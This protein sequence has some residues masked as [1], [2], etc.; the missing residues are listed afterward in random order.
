ME[1]PMIADGG[2]ADATDGVQEQVVDDVAQ[3]G[4]E[5][6][7]ERSVKFSLED[8]PTYDITE[9]KIRKYYNIPEGEDITEKEWKMAV[10]AMKQDLRASFV[11]NKST[12]AMKE[13]EQK[14][15]SFGELL[16]LLQSPET[17]VQV[18]EH[19]GLDVKNLSENYLLK[20]IEEQA[21]PEHE[22]ALKERERVIAER[23][24]KIQQE[25]ALKQQQIEEMQMAQAAEIM[26][27]QIIGA[28]EEYKLPK[29]EYTVRRI[30]HYMFEAGKRGIDASA[31]DVAPFVRKELEQINKSII[32]QADPDLI[33]ELLGEEKLKAIRQKDLEK[34]KTPMNIK[35]QAP[36][37]TPKKQKA[38]EPGLSWKEIVK[39]RAR[40]G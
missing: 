21:M 11:R 36:A 34:I 17:A 20:L 37:P 13:F 27:Q 1:E 31:S 28:M 26:N 30:A 32:D 6:V 39:Q 38:P 3:E 7:P 22:R 9:S 29:T 40:Q 16:S 12:Q 33:S 10:A 8:G 14:E 24:M 25:E 19:L 5:I 15:Q 4:Q 2:I 18:L 23:E 35:G